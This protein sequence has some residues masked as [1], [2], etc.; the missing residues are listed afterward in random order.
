MEVSSEREASPTEALKYLFTAL[1][2]D[3]I[4]SMNLVVGPR[5][6]SELR[7]VTIPRQVGSAVGV[8]PESWVSMTITTWDR[9]I[10]S[11]RPSGESAGA[12]AV[13]DPRRP[14]RLTSNREVTIPA[15]VLRAAGMKTGGL[16]AFK[17]AGREIRM[18]SADRVRGPV[19]D[20]P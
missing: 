6:I 2:T 18:F 16:V 4:I 8:E 12:Y 10:I 3:I 9:S 13:R 17:S 7:R 14:R 19:A 20:E 1:F 15:S 5:R 11:I